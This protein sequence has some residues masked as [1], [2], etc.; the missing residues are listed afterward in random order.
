M[1]DK[2]REKRLRD[3]TLASVVKEMAKPRLAASARKSIGRP[4]KGNS[5]FREWELLHNRNTNEDG[6]VALP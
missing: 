1:G 6:V 4:M 3:V 2:N 5:T